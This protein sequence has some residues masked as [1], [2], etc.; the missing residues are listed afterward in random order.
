MNRLL[1]IVDSGKDNLN[2]R[3]SCEHP[4]K[5]AGT[6]THKQTSRL[7]YFNDISRDKILKPM[8]PSVDVNTPNHFPV[9]EKS[10]AAL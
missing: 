10:F 3:L 5:E 4:H 9:F 2:L 7:F 8:C 1:T 6:D